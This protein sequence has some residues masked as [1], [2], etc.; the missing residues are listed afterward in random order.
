M[1]AGDLCCAGKAGILGTWKQL[2]TSVTS[3]NQLKIAAVLLKNR[4]ARG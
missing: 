1:L 3:K 2:S 4:L